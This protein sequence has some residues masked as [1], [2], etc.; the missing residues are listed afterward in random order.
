VATAFGCKTPSPHPLRLSDVATCVAA[1]AALTLGSVNS[2]LAWTGSAGGSVCRPF[3]VSSPR[4]S[5]SSFL[6]QLQIGQ[7]AQTAQT[8]TDNNRQNVDGAAW[9]SGAKAAG[10]SI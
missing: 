2:A 8:T 3:D 10:Q 6:L 4:L 1:V 5:T 7:A 9:L